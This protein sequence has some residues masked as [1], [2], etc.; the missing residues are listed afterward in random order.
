MDL[1]WD[2]LK[3]G[4]DYVNQKILK[5]HM[6]YS[7]VITKIDC[8]HATSLPGGNVDLGEINYDMINYEGNG[9]IQ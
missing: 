5:E 4:H 6:H 8:R 7:T 9:C 3:E 2:M 1:T